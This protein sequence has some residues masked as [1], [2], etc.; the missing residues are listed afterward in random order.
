[1]YAGIQIQKN[2]ETFVWMHSHPICILFVT[3]IMQLQHGISEIVTFVRYI[4]TYIIQ[5]RP[6][7][8]W[9]SISWLWYCKRYVHFRGSTIFL[10]FGLSARYIFFV[11]FCHDWSMYATLYNEIELNSWHCVFSALY[12]IQF[13]PNFLY[14]FKRFLGIITTTPTTKKQTEKKILT[15]IVKWQLKYQVSWYDIVTLRSWML[16]FFF[17]SLRLHIGLVILQIKTHKRVFL[18]EFMV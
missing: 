15:N 1:M 7:V 13:K 14:T 17:G 4:C 5:C 10:A 11:C 3:R 18:Y 6:L 16:H 12:D 2:D 8:I 9:L